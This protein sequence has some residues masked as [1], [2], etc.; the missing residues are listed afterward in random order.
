MCVGKTPSSRFPRPRAYL[1]VG[2]HSRWSF[3]VRRSAAK[4][5][6]VWLVRIHCVATGFVVWQSAVH[7]AARDS[8]AQHTAVPRDNQRIECTARVFGQEPGLTSSSIHSIYIAVPRATASCARH[9]TKGLGLT[10][11]PFLPALLCVFPPCR[12]RVSGSRAY[13]APRCVVSSTAPRSGTIPSTF[14]SLSRYNCE[15]SGRLRRAH[16]QALRQPF[17]QHHFIVVISLAWHFVDAGR[18]HRHSLD[19]CALYPSLMRLPPLFCCCN[20]PPVACL[21][22]AGRSS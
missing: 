5:Q 13:S 11:S 15:V 12:R 1:Q 18:R 20:A 6:F 9:P 10:L 22:L 19:H 7:A 17:R 2:S 3:P 14:C 16:G 21:F 8:G 4:A